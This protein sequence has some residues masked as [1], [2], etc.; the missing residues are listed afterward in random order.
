M[1]EPAGLPPPRSAASPLAK[2]RREG[3]P[4]TH[5][6]SAANTRGRVTSAD[7]DDSGRPGGIKDAS[8]STADP[9]GL[10]STFFATHCDRSLIRLHDGSE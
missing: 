6:L 9:A 4:P 3:L 5:A 1:L 2:R 8:Q 10:A 7:G